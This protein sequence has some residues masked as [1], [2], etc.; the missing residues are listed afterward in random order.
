MTMIFPF[1]HLL[2][3][4]DRENDFFGWPWPCTKQIPPELFRDAKTLQKEVLYDSLWLLFLKFW[5]SYFLM[6]AILAAILNFLFI[7]WGWDQNWI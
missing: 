2:V 4:F 7:N 1:L 5:N 6:A 3:I